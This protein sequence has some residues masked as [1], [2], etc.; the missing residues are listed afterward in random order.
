MQHIHLTQNGRP[1]VGNEHLAG[2]QLHQF[3]HAAGAEGGADGGCDGFGGD[4][5]GLADVFAFGAFLEGFAAE[6]GG[7]F[8]I[9]ELVKKLGNERLTT[10]IVDDD[11]NIIASGDDGDTDWRG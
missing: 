5:V 11:D 1:I 4:D 7:H 3:V 9:M 8:E 10:V 6:E 2:G